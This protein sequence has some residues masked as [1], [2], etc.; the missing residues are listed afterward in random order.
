MI[1]AFT[2]VALG[3]LGFLFTRQLVLRNYRFLVALSWTAPYVCFAGILGLGYRRFFFPDSYGLTGSRSAAF[4]TAHST[5]VEIRDGIRHSRTPGGWR[6][7]SA[8]A[9]TRYLPRR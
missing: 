9:K 8:F 7:I 2:N 4:R 5:K 1:F 3:L 6:F